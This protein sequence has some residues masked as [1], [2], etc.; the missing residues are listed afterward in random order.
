MVA[1]YSSKTG[2]QLFSFQGRHPCQNKP[3]EINLAVIHPWVTAS[4]SLRLSGPAW[5][6]VGDDLNT[7]MSG[8]CW[9]VGGEANWWFLH[10]P[11]G[12]TPPLHLYPISRTARRLLSLLPVPAEGLRADFLAAC[13]TP[14]F[15]SRLPLPQLEPPG[16]TSLTSKHIL[17]PATLPPL[18][19]SFILMAEPGGHTSS[20][21]LTFYKITG[22]SQ[23]LR[24]S[25]SPC[26]SWRWRLFHLYALQPKTGCLL[27][28]HTHCQACRGARVSWGQ[29][30]AVGLSSL[31]QTVAPPAMGTGDAVQQASR[32]FF[33]PFCCRSPSLPAQKMSGTPTSPRASDANAGLIKR[34]GSREAVEIYTPTLQLRLKARRAVVRVTS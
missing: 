7:V 17:N 25:V 19:D 26:V 8:T 4:K 5:P 21:L 32:S 10:V 6:Q 2:C 20:S 24:A 30:V 16:I 27:L 12:W 34:L 29:V 3:S 14:C 15:P 18:R 11:G 13:M 31:W 22:L 9:V 1:R 23:P 33:S 28:C